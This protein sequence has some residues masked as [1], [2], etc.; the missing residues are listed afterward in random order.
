[1]DKM[2]TI[3]AVILGCLP[4]MSQAQSTEL[5]CWTIKGEQMKLTV[6]DNILEIPDGIAAID[7]CG[8]EAITLDRSSA[9]PNCLYYTDESTSVE[10]L[11]NANVVCDGVCEGLLLTDDACFYCPIA[12]FATDAMLRYTPRY[13]DGEVGVD[14]DFN[15][16]CNETV[17]LPFDADFVIPEDVNGPM[18]DGWLQMAKFHGFD[19]NML[20][21]YQSYE[22][23][24]KANTPYLVTF[25]FGAYG[26]QILFCGQDKTVEET[27][28]ASAD[29]GLYNFEGITISEDERPGYYRYYRGEE[30]FFIH[31]GD[32]MPMEPFRCFIVSS[33]E[34]D[35]P[36]GEE[37]DTCGKT[38]GYAVIGDN[39]DGIDTRNRQRSSKACYDLQG[40]QMPDG[41][42]SRGIFISGGVKVIK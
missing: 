38:L 29:E 7:L 6:E 20:V 30:P 28:A 3:I 33:D 26:T 37:T 27:A 1:M 4:F 13:D 11:P 12:F 8:M 15:Q 39:L 23:C 34:I 14:T 10:G 41:N 18:P 32:E 40:R 35:E 21:F 22:E 19:D 16:P 42:R 2:R 5:T 24:L 17:F 31:Y 25:A 9:N 36:S